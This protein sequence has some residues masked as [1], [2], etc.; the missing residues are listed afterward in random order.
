M[1]EALAALVGR[2]TGQEIERTNRFAGGDISGATEVELADGSRVVAKMG[3][4]VDVEARMLRAMAQSDARVPDV[5]GCE[6][7]VLLIEHLPAGGSLSGNAWPSL[8]AQLVALDDLDSENYGWDEN[9]ALRDIVVENE[10]CQ[11][12]PTFWA[13][14]RLLCHV[15]HLPPQLAQRV[16]ELAKALPELLPA[17]P[18]PVLVHGDL[19]GGNVIVDRQGN[20]ALIDP[21]AYY[22]DREVDAASLTV[23]DTPPESF[24]D[25]LDLEAG[26]Q[27]R[28]PIYR[29]WMW[30]LHVRLFGGG[31]VGACNRELDRLGF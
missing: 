2:V 27:E 5:L 22:G 29:L 20:A 18:R 17:R 4:V 13:D 23:F 19:W 16:K 10:P 3:P 30:L 28:Q 11:D 14:R 21:C 1:S 26:W 9:Y 12:W 15:P 25:A 6:N 24:F 8:A 31:Y 7:D